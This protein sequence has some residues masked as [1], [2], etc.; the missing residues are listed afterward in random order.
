MIDGLFKIHLTDNVPHSLMT[1]HDCIGK[2]RLVMD[3]NS[4]FL[5]HR[6]L[7]HI[8]IDRIKRLVN[9]RVLKTN[10]FTDFATCVD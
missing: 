6:R 1:S 9:D 2:K 3:E 8:S 5:W 10:D 4:S 7:G